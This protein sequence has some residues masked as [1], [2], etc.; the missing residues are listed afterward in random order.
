M[1]LL[2]GN[3]MGFTHSGRTSD[4]AVIASVGGSGM[5]LGYG[6]SFDGAREC[7]GMVDGPPCDTTLAKPMC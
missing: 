3:G 6:Q 2:D 5:S 7:R 1:R 4:W